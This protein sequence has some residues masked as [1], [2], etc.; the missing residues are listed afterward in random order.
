MPMLKTVFSCALFNWHIVCGVHLC[1]AKDTVIPRSVNRRI[2][3]KMNE[4]PPSKGSFGG[5]LYIE[6]VKRICYDTTNTSGWGV[7]AK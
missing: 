7:V 1:H 6:V 2:W 3:H 4:Q 5:G